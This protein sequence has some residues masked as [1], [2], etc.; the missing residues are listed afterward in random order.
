MIL[1]FSFPFLKFCVIIVT[2]ENLSFCV[3][4]TF[5]KFLSSSDPIEENQK[6]K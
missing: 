2:S 5:G 3:L 1:V 4:F 6:N